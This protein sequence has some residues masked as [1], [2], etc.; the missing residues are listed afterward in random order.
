[1]AGLVDP[2]E[3]EVRLEGRVAPLLELGV[4]FHEELTGREN[5]R[6]NASLMGLSRRQRA[7]VYDAIVDFSEVESFIDEPLR[8]YSAGMKLRLAFSVAIHCD[9]DI[10]LIDEVLAV[11]DQAFQTKCMERIHEFRRQGK[12]LLC[13]SHSAAM[14]Q[15]FCDRGIWLDHGRIVK[16]G[17]AAEVQN[18]YCPPAAAVQQL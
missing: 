7:Q 13:V 3:G 9:P 5:V 11:G 6:L 1:V 18:A 4:G 14:V 17:T 12:T 10:L 8:A 16:S 15:R 2:D